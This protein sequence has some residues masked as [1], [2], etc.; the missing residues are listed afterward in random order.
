MLKGLELF[1][2]SRSIGKVLEKKGFKV[3]SVDINDFENIDLVCDIEFL[4]V[5]DL[6]FI[7]DFFWASPI[8]TTYSIAGIAHHRTGEIPKSE[9]AVK[10]DRVIK[11][12]LKLLAELLILNPKLLYYIENP[13]GMLRKMSFMRGLNRTTVTYCSYADNRM[14]PTDIWS[15]NIY[16]LFNLKGW[17]PRPICF[18]NNRKCHHE[19]SPRSSKNS[20]TQGRKNNYERSLIPVELCEEIIN[21]SLKKILP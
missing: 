4:Q 17:P 13:R 21:Y 20:G 14:K 2:G 5:Q 1:A 19:P 8:C 9:F 16:D 7:P 12:M 10:S 18:N 11:A 3:C 6:P 15:N